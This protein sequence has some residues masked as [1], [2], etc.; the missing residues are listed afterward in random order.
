[1]AGHSGHHSGS[2]LAVHQFYNT[3]EESIPD[4]RPLVSFG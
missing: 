1:M 3:L 4:A 2:A